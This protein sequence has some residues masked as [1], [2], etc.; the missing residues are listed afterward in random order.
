MTGIIDPWILLIFAMAMA[1]PA[2]SGMV[3]SEIR[4]VNRPDRSE[5]G[6]GLRSWLC[7]VMKASATRRTS[8]LSGHERANLYGGVA[9]AMGLPEGVNPL[10]WRGIVEM[11]D[12]LL[13]VPVVITEDFD[14]SLGE[15][16]YP[17]PESPALDAARAHP[18]FQAFLRFDQFPFWKVE[19][20]G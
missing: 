2:L 6:P 18:A 4:G 13:D 3:S 9:H 7:W 12:S 15:V 20:A 10:R 19:P 8:A 1:A 11:P 17:A 16:D 14:P 5:P